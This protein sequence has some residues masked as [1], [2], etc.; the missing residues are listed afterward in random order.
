MP[1]AAHAKTEAGQPA[2]GHLRPEQEGLLRLWYVI[3]SSNDE[4]KKYETFADEK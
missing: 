2:E 3:H 4:K 1:R